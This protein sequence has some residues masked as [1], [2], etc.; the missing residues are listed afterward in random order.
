MCQLGS[1]CLENQ[2]EYDY[3]YLIKQLITVHKYLTPQEVLNGKRVIPG[4]FKDSFEQ[5]RMERNR[6][7]G[8]PDC[9]VCSTGKE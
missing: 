2:L 4:K 9:Q 8:N 5:V 1:G 3:S 7:H 6:V